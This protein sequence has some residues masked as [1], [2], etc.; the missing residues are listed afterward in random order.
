MSAY[1]WHTTS[2]GGNNTADV[3]PIH[4]AHVAV[5]TEHGVGLYTV[6]GWDNGADPMVWA[7]G[8]TNRDEHV[9]VWSAM[10]SSTGCIG[11]AAGEYGDPI[12]L[13][14]GE[15]MR[16]EYY[17]DVVRVGHRTV[18]ASTATCTLCKHVVHSSDIAR[19][20]DTGRLYW[21]APV[22]W[23][24]SDELWTCTLCPASGSRLEVQYHTATA[25]DDNGRAL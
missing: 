2:T 22:A 9:A 17:P 10:L 18:T 21:T 12:V 1:A 24:S 5:S 15:C 25:H 3:A 19:A 8:A 16:G 6:E 4:G 14:C 7:E 11:Q 23:L 20:M 13:V